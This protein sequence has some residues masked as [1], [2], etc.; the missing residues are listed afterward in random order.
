M[1]LFVYSYFMLPGSKDHTVTCD[2]TA[3]ATGEMLKVE[4]VWSGE[5][6]GPAARSFPQFIH[7]RGLNVSPKFICWNPNPAVMV[8]GG[9]DWGGDEVIRLEPPEW[10]QSL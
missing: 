2:E 5:T 8:L 9:G 1:G 6:V 3:A 10:H 4:A 7:F